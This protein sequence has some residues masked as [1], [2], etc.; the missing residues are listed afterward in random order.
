MASRSPEPTSPARAG[1]GIIARNRRATFDYELEQRFE[2]GLVLTGSEVKA[3]RSRMADLSDAW[4]SV[5][6]GEAFV[7]GL[8]IPE[9]SGL[10]TRHAPKRVRK[11]LLR[12]REI[13]ELARAIER[14][15]MTAIA[16]TLYFRAGRA[17]L[18]IALARGKRQI[19]KR[20]ALKAKEADREAAAAMRR[21]GPQ[22]GGGRW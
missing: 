10:A 14:D 2:A 13:T 21:S 8:S 18:E 15:G 22:R 3:L 5:E 12:A 6:D 7:R 16:L 11:L 17:K 4:C 20:H 1:D 19:D 9:L